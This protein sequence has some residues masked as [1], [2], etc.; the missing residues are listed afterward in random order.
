MVEGRILS[1]DGAEGIQPVMERA[2]RPSDPERACRLTGR[3]IRVAIWGGFDVA[4]YGDLLFPRIFENE[5]SRRLPGVE[6]RSFSPLGYLN[7]VPMDSGIRAAP[8]GSWTQDRLEHFASEFHLVVVGGGDIIHLRDD[9]YPGFYG[10]LPARVGE[11]KP[12]RFYIDGLG[13]ELERSTPVVWNAVGVPFDFGLQDAER[14]RLA[15]EHRPYLAVRDHASRKRVLATG[16]TREPAVV[17]DTG[18]ALGRLFPRRTLEDILSGLKRRGFYPVD[19]QAVVVQGNGYLPEERRSEIAAALQ[20]L[21]DDLAE[22]SIVLLETGPCH[23]DGE[24]ADDLVR[25]LGGKVF[26]LPSTAAV[27]EIAACIAGARLFVGTSLHGH[28]TA[29]CFRVASVMVN[30]Q[31]INKLD[32]LAAMAEQEESVVT[33]TSQLRGALDAALAGS[34]SSESNVLDGLISRVDA[35]FDVIAELAQRSSSRRTTASGSL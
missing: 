25:R 6:I 34:P 15:I 2:A 22:L 27:E 20:E 23:Q 10:G 21:R 32:E 14:V 31:G 13:P 4:N 29:M 30:V 12:S 18:V 9:L 5:M 16:I 1:V 28:I 11:L 26:R 24:F 33:D 19:G 17:P 3:G 7:P 8:L 35:H